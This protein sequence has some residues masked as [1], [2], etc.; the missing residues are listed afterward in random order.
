MAKFT[1]HILC[2]ALKSIKREDNTA[3]KHVGVH[4][5]AVDLGEEHL[6]LRKA[7]CLTK[8]KQR[9]LN[10]SF[11]FST[12]CYSPYLFLCVDVFVESLEGINIELH[13]LSEQVKVALQDISGLAATVD[14]AKQDVLQSKDKI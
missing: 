4:Q 11:Y 8:D 14:D 7:H 9:L 12:F 13:K 10:N 6:E 5:R 1:F 2:L 3:N